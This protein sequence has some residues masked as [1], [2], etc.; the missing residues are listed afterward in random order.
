MKS[1][2]VRAGRMA[3]A[4][5]ACLGLCR[6]NFFRFSAITENIFR[7]SRFTSEIKE[8]HACFTKIHCAY[9]TKKKVFSENTE[10][11]NQK[12]GKRKFACLSLPCV[13]RLALAEVISFPE[14][15]PWLCF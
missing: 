12:N 15:K 5:P 13:V 6:R 9:E 1:S 3:R 7:F 2:P 14:S 4:G 10:R 11:K 8:I